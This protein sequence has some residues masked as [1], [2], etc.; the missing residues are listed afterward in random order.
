MRVQLPGPPAPVVAGTSS[1]PT[2][3]TS[4]A[5]LN[6]AR[7]ASCRMPKLP[8]GTVT[9]LF[10]DVEGSTRLLGE[11]GDAYADLLAEHRRL[12]RDAFTA[13]DGVEVDTQGDAFFVAFA[14]ASDAAAAAAD[15]PA[16]ARPDAGARAHGPAH[17]RAAGD[18]GG[19]RRH[20]RPPR[21]ARR[22]GRATAARCSSPSRPRA[23][24]TAQELRDLGLHRLKD[25]GETRIYQLGDGEFPPLKTLYQTNLP[26]PANPLIGRK[27]ELVDVMRLLAV[28]RARVVTITG[29]GGTGKTRFSIAA[30]SEVH[31][32]VRGRDVVRR[33]QRGARPRAGAARAVGAGARCARRRS[34]STS[35]SGET[36]VV[37]DNLEQVVDAAAD[38]AG[39]GRAPARGSSCSAR[40]ARRCGSRAEHEY[41]LRPLPES[42]A[43]ELF[44]QRGGAPTT[45]S[46]TS[47]RPRSASASTGCRSRSS[48][49]RRACRCSSRRCC[50]S[51]SSSGCRCSS[52]RS[53]DLPERQRTLH[54]T[55]AWSYELLDADEQQ[56]FRRLAVFAGGM[57]LEAAEAVCD[58][59]VDLLESL[60]D[61][62]LLAPP[63]RALRHARDDPRVRRRAARRERRGRCAPAPPCGVLR[64]AGGRRSGCRWRRSCAAPSSATTLPLREA[65]NLRA[66]LGWALAHRPRRASPPGW[67]PGSRTSG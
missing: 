14:R 64:R 54:A 26:T 62:S 56:L 44:R 51:G 39:A 32:G 18:G 50:S 1:S 53:R 25:V 12:L 63:R 3:A 11:H 37:L 28:D 15:G 66:A 31:R 60:V 61:K 2:A 34:P 38:L 67:R 27:K 35:A 45:R 4:V 47:S 59:D 48:S 20:G 52:S 55:I 19:L 6:I 8:A 58:A 22:G 7:D 65:G 40:A 5:H 49:P 10:T 24:W 46:P 30:A 36:L 9:F 42:P 17:G 23:C 29:P 16:S 57:T 21:R 43:V 13:H 41:P 33:P